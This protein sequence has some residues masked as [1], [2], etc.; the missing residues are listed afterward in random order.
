MKYAFLIITLFL[1]TKTNAQVC[2]ANIYNFK[3]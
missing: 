2:K 3:N 1:F